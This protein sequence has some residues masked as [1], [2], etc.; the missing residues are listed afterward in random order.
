MTPDFQPSSIVVALAAWKAGGLASNS[1]GYVIKAII[2]S[3]A[4][5]NSQIVARPN[6]L[7]NPL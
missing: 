4:H 5:F 2:P 3:V 6:N 7:N 1:I